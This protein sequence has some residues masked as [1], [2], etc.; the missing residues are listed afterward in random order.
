MLSWYANQLQTLAVL[1]QKNDHICL[2]WQDTTPLLTYGM[3]CTEETSL[4]GCPRGLY[5]PRYE[6]ERADN[7]GR[8]SRL[9]HHQATGSCLER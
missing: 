1:L 7:L 9:P 4:R 5:T 6:F 8:L 3:S 2:L